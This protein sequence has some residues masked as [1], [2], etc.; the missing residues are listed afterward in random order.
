[1]AV[2]KDPDGNGIAALRSMVD[3]KG[4]NVLDV[5]CGDGKL[6]WLYAGQASQV[7][8]IDPDDEK[9]VAAR[10]SLPDALEDRVRIIQTSL[11]DFA[12][13]FRGRKFDI[14]IFG[15]SL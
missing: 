3:L 10:A 8:A 7:T 12:A 15:W 14:I 11:A 9:I 1:M 13:S 2:I 6:T 5:G 4:Q